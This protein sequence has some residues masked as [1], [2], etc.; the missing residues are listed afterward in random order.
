MA[1]VMHLRSTGVR[2]NRAAA[3]AHNVLACFYI[4][5]W[6]TLRS[7]ANTVTRVA[8]CNPPVAALQGWWALSQIDG[9]AARLREAQQLGLEP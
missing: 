4:I 6:S 8:S 2:F 7:A 9:L 5:L 3:I 1:F